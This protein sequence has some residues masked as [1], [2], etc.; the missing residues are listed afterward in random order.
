MEIDEQTE[1]PD[2]P[3]MITEDNYEYEPVPW[4]GVL[5][6]ESTKSGD[7]RSFAGQS[8][9]WRGL[10]LPLKFQGFQ[11]EGH[12]GSFVVGRIDNIWRDG[13]L[14][15]AEGVF[16]E[17]AGAYEVI[18][19]LA[20]MMLRGVSV[21]VD[22]AEGEVDEDTME[23]MLTSA[24]IASATIC[25]IPAFEEAFISIGRWSDLEQP[26]P[27]EPEDDGEPVPGMAEEDGYAATTHAAAEQ[28]APVPTRTKD[29]PGWITHPK[30][31]KRITDYW[32]D[33]EGA[34]L[35]GWGIPGDFNRCRIQLGKYVQNPDWL[36]GLCAN[37]H[38][39]A[40]RSWP[41][42]HTT[43][44]LEEGK[45]P[46]QDEERKLAVV[47]SAA[48]TYTDDGIVM[49]HEWFTDPGLKA[50]TPIVVTPE[51]RVYGHVAEWGTC[52]VGAADECVAPPQSKTGYSYFHTGGTVLTDQG[53]VDIG[54]I[55]MASGHPSTRW[56]YRRAVSYYDNNSTAVADVVAGEDQ[57][58]IWVSGAV[59]PGIT[60]EQKYALR[61]STLSGDW[62]DVHGNLELSIALAVNAGGFPISRKPSFAV[63]N[64]RQ[65]SLVAAGMLPEEPHEVDMDDI[66][67]AVA[68]RIEERAAQQERRR[69][70][71]SA[72]AALVEDSRQE[73]KQ[74]LVTALSNMG[75]Q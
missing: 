4:Y 43:A 25:A 72:V 63:V 23:S 27:A 59:R 15:K 28:F 19:L 5:A 3:G 29:G 26:E 30:P 21:D 17:S 9:R 57:F 60:E 38:Y 2:G 7:R 68:Q 1:R 48:V 75:V 71:A 64:G 69:R 67:D 8:L 51:G 44:P 53:L 35:I 31:T 11:D 36:A 54:H 6:P 74:R 40:L 42:Q 13:D 41:G 56:S 10:P 33:G 32:V 73:R 16:D 49:P 50:P 24:R 14:I 12:N 65:M 46:E 39:R 66:V 37:L 58:G 55:V 20:N 70:A 34:A 45:L 62:R 52:H 22:D 47:A 61:A 18:R